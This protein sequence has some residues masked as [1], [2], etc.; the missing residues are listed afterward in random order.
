VLLTNGPAPGCLLPMIVECVMVDLVDNRLLWIDS[1]LFAVLG[2]DLTTG[3]VIF[4]DE[5]G[6]DDKGLSGIAAFEVTS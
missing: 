4:V 6:R 2:W 3:D 5:F 1:H